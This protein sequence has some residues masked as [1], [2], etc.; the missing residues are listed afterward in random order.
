MTGE[1]KA[2]AEVRYASAC[3]DFNKL[4]IA[5][6]S[7]RQAKAYRTLSSFAVLNAERAHAA[8]EVASIDSHQFGGT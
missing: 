5:F 1:I 4:D 2:K 7:T 8:V 6:I 3:R